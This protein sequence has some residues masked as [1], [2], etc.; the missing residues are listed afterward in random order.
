MNQGPGRIRARSH[1]TDPFNI[2]PGEPAGEAPAVSST[3]VEAEAKISNDL[4]QLRKPAKESIHLK[5]KYDVNRIGMR[6][7]LV[8]VLINGVMAVMRA[9]GHA[10]LARVS[11]PVLLTVSTG[12]AGVG[13]LALSFD[14]PDGG[15]PA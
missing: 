14:P 13:L 9:N 6:G 11:P 8:L 4:E 5:G 2:A 10:I 12:V 3:T 15:R 1:C 7:I